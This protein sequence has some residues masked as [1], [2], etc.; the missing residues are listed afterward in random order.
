MC[1]DILIVEEQTITVQRSF[2]VDMVRA[3]IVTG[4]SL[5]DW[6]TS[7]IVQTDILIGCD[8]GALYLIEHGYSPH[9]AVGDFD[10]VS[11]DER[12]SIR[13]SSSHYIDYDPIDKDK[14]DTEI[15]LDWALSQ[16]FDEII[17]LG[18]LGSRFDHTL[19]NI[20]LLKKAVDQGGLCKIID[21][22]N[23]ILLINQTTTIKKGNYTYVSLLS[24]SDIV[25]GVSL[26]GFKYPLHKATL[27]NGQTLGVSNILLTQEA[28][29]ELEQGYLLVIQSK[30]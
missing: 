26:L 5:G 28:T 12:I 1:Y 13:Q 9:I 2:D 22:Y 29:I 15:A 18:A 20:H 21:P 11:N 4:G 19:A 10:S 17:I 25:S 14:T 6:V 24:L 30:D 16:Y 7:W 27:K 23:E 3:I 8:R